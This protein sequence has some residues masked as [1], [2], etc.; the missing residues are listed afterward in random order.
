VIQVSDLLEDLP[1]ILHWGSTHR[2]IRIQEGQPN[3]APPI[4]HLLADDL[5][6]P[7]DV[8]YEHILKVSPL[9]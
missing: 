3:K 5:A 9:R 1:E 6:I 8:V 4:N 2:S 7:D